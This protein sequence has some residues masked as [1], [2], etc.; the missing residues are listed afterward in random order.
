MMMK[1]I[2]KESDPPSKLGF[3]LL[4]ASLENH[5]HHEW[6]WLIR[7][8]SIEEECECHSW[9]TFGK[10][11]IKASCSAPLELK[12]TVEIEASKSHPW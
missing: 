1:T 2:M 9:R 7:K 10:E 3:D 5:H 8:E 11:D 12:S 6:S 4:A